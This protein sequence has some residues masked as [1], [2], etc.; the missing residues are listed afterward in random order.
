MVISSITTTACRMF[1]SAS[2]YTV[3]ILIRLDSVRVLGALLQTPL[4]A[5]FGVL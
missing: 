5:S 1:E 2:C 3:V 4:E